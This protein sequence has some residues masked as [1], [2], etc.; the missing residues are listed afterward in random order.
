MKFL[1][2]MTLLVL[3]VGRRV[4]GKSRIKS[5]SKEQLKA[6][7]ITREQYDQRIA[8]IKADILHKLGMRAL[9]NVTGMS[10]DLLPAAL[11]TEFWS[12]QARAE[13]EA[14]RRRKEKEETQKVVLIGKKPEVFSANCDGISCLEVK[15]KIDLKDKVIQSMR[16]WLYRER[17]TENT[18]DY[19][20]I[21]DAIDSRL[22]AKTTPTKLASKCGWIVSDITDDVTDD[23]RQWLRNASTLDA[24]TQMKCLNCQ[25]YNE[26]RFLPFITI[27][28]RTPS[29]P[30]IRKKRKSAKINIPQRLKNQ[31]KTH[32]VR[33][34]CTRSTPCCV[35]PFIVSFKS[36]GF[37]H[38]VVYPESYD[39]GFCMG[40]CRSQ[41]HVYNEHDDLMKQLRFYGK[42]LPAIKQCSKIVQGRNG[43]FVSG[44]ESVS[45]LYM[46]DNKKKALYVRSIE[47]MR[48]AKCDCWSQRP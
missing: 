6:L 26:K 47:G 19:V 38:F 35:K 3:F 23:A 12:E 21:S 13:V 28:I 10:R 14:E 45:L 15:F 5:G 2:M 43:C 41:E 31:I 37:D 32:S 8:H 22:L 44:Y 39:A 33:P 40:A 4:D 46:K 7:G 42:P 9:P 29:A 11:M 48:A 20:T 18:E 25:F 17:T 1:I 36:I 16:V 24:H 34:V 30:I 27:T